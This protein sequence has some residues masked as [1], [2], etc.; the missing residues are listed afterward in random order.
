[1]TATTR[2]SRVAVLRMLTIATLGRSDAVPGSVAD[3]D[4]R[5]SMADARSA[6]QIA[7][8]VPVDRLDSLGYER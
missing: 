6:L 1:M 7:S 8:G 4:M 3:A 2:E 5:T